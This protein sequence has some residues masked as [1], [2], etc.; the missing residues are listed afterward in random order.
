MRTFLS[1]A[2]ATG[3][4]LASLAAPRSAGAQ[5]AQ[6]N[7]VVMLR[8]GGLLR[9]TISE[10][11]PGSHVLMVTVT[12]ETKRIKAAEVSYAGPSSGAPNAAPN[13]GRN[14][15]SL[16]TV[17]AAEAPVKLRSEQPE[18]TFYL[19]TGESMGSAVT[20]GFG[21]GY[22]YRG[23]SMMPSTAF[24]SVRG[25]SYG[26][27]CTAPCEATVAAG[28][29]SMALSKGNGSPIEAEELVRVDGPSTLQ[30]TYTSYAGLRVAGFAVG[31]ASIIA[32][33]YLVISSFGTKDVCEGNFCQSEVDVD[34]TRLVLGSVVLVGGSIAG[35]VMA[36]KSDETSIR[37][38]PAASGALPGRGSVAAS[39]RQRAGSGPVP[40]V[41]VALSF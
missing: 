1:F 27:V 39:D 28:S 35:S 29:Y 18:V 31:L 25:R 33:G 24:T 23:A 9:G 12:G 40:G 5:S 4:T 16:V 6:A 3:F 34:T 15:P 13:G 22:G 21:M 10:Y 14:R 32:G 36:G 11:V 20:T 38:L 2:L 8:N 17:N 26:R 19:R 37:V 7:D 41:S 30:G